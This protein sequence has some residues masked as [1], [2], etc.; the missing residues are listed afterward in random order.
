MPNTN[1]LDTPTSM[2]Q[3]VLDSI[4]SRVFWKDL[5]LAYRGGNR[6][7]LS[8][9]GVTSLEELN[10]K[11]DFELAWSREQAEAFR[12][13]D[14]EVIA[15]G[16][17]KIEIEEKQTQA[18]GG[19]FWLQ[20]SK[21]PLF[22][23]AGKVVGVLG[24]Y[25]DIT[26]RKTYQQRIEFQANHD[27]LTGLANRRNLQ[28]ILTDFMQ[29]QREHPAALL[30]IDLDHF[31]TINDSLGH[32]VGDQLLCD[33]AQRLREV[34]PTNDAVYRIGGDEFSVLVNLAQA[35]VDD[36]TAHTT[37]FADE[38]IQSLSL[39]FLIS[40][41]THYLGASVGITLIHP[42]GKNTD[43]KF[44][45]ADIALYAA[46]NSGRNCHAIYDAELGNQAEYQHTLQSH[47]RQALQRR[48]F[49]LVYQPQYDYDGNVIGA[50]ALIRWNNPVLGFVGPDQFIPIAEQTGMIHAIGDWILES[51]MALIE[52]VHQSLSEDFVL[53]INISP[54]QFQQDRFC[55]HI[56]KQLDQ[57]HTP[58]KHLQIEI[59]ESTLLNHEELAIQKLHRLKSL[60]ISIAIDDFGTGYSSL[61]YLTRLPI[62]KLKIDQSF[63]R[64]ITSDRRHA[65][66]VETIISMTQNLNMEVIAEGVETEREREFLARQQCYQYQGYF[67]SKPLPESEFITLLQNSHSS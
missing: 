41:H 44:Q 11:T 25:T 4:P 65:C 20:T 62:D 27:Q 23:N 49:H 63:V 34:A 26:E 12:A 58:N 45:Q 1:P 6:R 55:D 57:Y 43:K 14:R 42:E 3:L 13:D 39:P 60:G 18:D 40:S 24:T 31:K 52:Q 66:I 61:A 51:A 50:E 36:I 29:Q 59:T 54:I 16:Q 35:P 30:I 2:L 64:R 53:A 9:A 32:K 17:A 5:D 37:K 10:G 47:L 46:K 67:F 56:E 21:I 28:S 38:I 7:F 48:E 33:V 22:D 15:N 19:T 8:D